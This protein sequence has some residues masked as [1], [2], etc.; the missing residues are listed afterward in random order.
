[1][2]DPANCLSWL[3]KVAT[4][5]ALSHLK[6]THPEVALP[7]EELWGSSDHS[8]HI[9]AHDLVMRILRTLPPNQRAALVLHEVYG[10]SCDEIGTALGLS[11]GAVRTTLWRARDAFRARY[12]EE[13]GR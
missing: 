8:G 12:L 10:F 11:R 7:Q 3:L 5:L 9:A 4:N 13:E 6:R 2:R 1:V